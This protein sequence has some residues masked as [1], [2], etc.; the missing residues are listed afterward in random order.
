MR[1]GT[2]FGSPWL[3]DPRSDIERRFAEFHAKNPHILR[4]LER[5]AMRLL[6]V[7]APRIGVKALWESMRYDAL[8]RTDARDWKLNNS[9]TACYARLLID[10]NPQLAGVIETRR[11]H[12]VAA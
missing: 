9:Y 4:E 11:R 10:R 3:A 2:L 5:R 12:E 8:V 6:E 7:G 1:Q